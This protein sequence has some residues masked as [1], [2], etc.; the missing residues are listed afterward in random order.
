MRPARL[1]RNRIACF[2]AITIHD[3]NLAGEPYAWTF[4]SPDGPNMRP[5]RDRLVRLGEALRLREGDNRR[6]PTFR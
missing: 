2:R 3:V 6:I 4:L 1:Q 5:F